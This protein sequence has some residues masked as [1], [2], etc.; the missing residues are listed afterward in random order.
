MSK[1]DIKDAA[2]AGSSAHSLDDEAGTATAGGNSDGAGS[3]G[4]PGGRAAGARSS[5]S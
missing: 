2:A 3:A 1:Q 4:A 5:C